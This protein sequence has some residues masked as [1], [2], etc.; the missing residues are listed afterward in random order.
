MYLFKIRRL[1]F[2]SFVDNFFFFFNDTATTE[3]YTLSLHDALPFPH[4]RAHGLAPGPQRLDHVTADEAAAAGDEDGH[5][6][7][8]LG[9]SK[10]R[11]TTR[12]S[13][14]AARTTAPSGTSR[15]TTA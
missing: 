7:P 5:A 13:R 1:T 11:E 10:G 2:I 3:I 14:P 9:T 15:R 6:G 8:M 4:Q 12:A